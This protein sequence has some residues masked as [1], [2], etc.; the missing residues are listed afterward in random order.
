M[1]TRKVTVGSLIDAMHNIR[2]QKRELAAK[3]KVLNAEYEALELKL[4][5]TMDQ[6]GLTKST[7]R[8]S[9]ASV[10]VVKQF[11]FITEGGFEAFFAYA[12]KIKRPDLVQRR[13][14]APAVR[15]LW[16][17]KGTVPGLTPYDKRVIGLTD[18]KQT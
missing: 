7:G 13:L 9:T 5:E 10:N 14:S 2:N 1:A 18:I 16:Q 17:L 6:E 8:F 12:A 3:E 15:E 4:L 11:N